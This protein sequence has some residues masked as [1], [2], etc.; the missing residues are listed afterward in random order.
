MQK[1]ALTVRDVAREGA[2]SER[3]VYRLLKDGRLK[4]RKLGRKTLIMSEDFRALLDSLPA[5]DLEAAS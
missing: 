2:M 5:A 1:S 4:A 3:Q